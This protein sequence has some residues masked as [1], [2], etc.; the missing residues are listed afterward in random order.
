MTVRFV[1]R[2]ILFLFLIGFVAFASCESNE[3]IQMNS[4]TLTAEEALQLVLVDDIS[5]EV[6]DVIEDDAILGESYAIT[7]DA[8]TSL[9]MPNQ[10][11]GNHPDCLQRTVE[12]TSNG[13]TVILDF[14]EGCSGKKGS[15]FSGKIIIAYVKADG[16]FSKTITFENFFI[17]GNAVE[18]GKSIS[19]VRENNNGNPERTYEVAMSVTFTTGETMFTNGKRFKEKVYGADTSERGDDVVLITGNWEVVRK[20]GNVKSAAIVKSLRRE[21][22]CKY[23]VSGTIDITKNTALYTL[24]FGGGSCDNKATITNASG[25]V[26]EISLRKRKK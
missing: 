11:K 20:N 10:T 18:G 2:N 26:K 17:N 23:I 7:S 3:D 1:K 19:K 15:I 16:S 14:G 13:K 24:D 5:A 12:D 8:T 25:A 22:A 21:Y 6:D 4:D 9:S